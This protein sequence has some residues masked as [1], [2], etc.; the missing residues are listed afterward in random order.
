MTDDRSPEPGRLDERVLSALHGL[1]GR[2]AFGGLRRVLHAHPESLSRSLRRLEREGLVERLDGGYR[3]LGP[4]GGEEQFAGPE[5][6]LRTVARVELPAGPPAADVAEQLAGRWFGSLRWVGRIDRPE[7]RLLAWARRDGD[8]L[9][10][11]GVRHRQLSVY[12]PE[13]G[14]QDQ[15]T[16]GDAPAYDLLVH[17]AELLRAPVAAV[18]ESYGSA[19]RAFEL[20]PAPRTIAG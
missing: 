7:G 19:V 1:P 5:P 13:S 9:V 14:D 8:G 6:R 12:V 4:S 11:L 20:G 3:A 10:L 16:G 2:L 18:A 15:P 17:A